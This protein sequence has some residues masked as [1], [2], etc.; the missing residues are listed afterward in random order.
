MKINFLFAAGLLLI[1]CNLGFSQ[2]PGDVALN[3]IM[4]APT[5]STNEWFELYNNTSSPFNMAN[6][7]WKDATA[8]L[9]TITTA[10]INLPANGY[11]VIC[12]DST[13]FRTAFPAYTGLLIQSNGWSSLNNTG[14]ENL[15]IFNASSVVGTASSK[16][17]PASYCTKSGT[18][19][20]TA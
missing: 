18:S 2:N 10:N 20:E 6:W 14:S 13:A 11:A 3:E 16:T 8:T 7:K 15:I 5:P 19:A 1:L 17:R 12:E 4:Y 9:R